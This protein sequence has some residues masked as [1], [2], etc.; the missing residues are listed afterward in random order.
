MT[1]TT[2]FFLL[3]N[4]L[5][6]STAFAVAA[7]LLVLALGKNHAR[8][9]YW[10]WWIASLKF[11]IPFSL[12]V[13]LGSH[14]SWRPAPSEP[15][16]PTVSA[17]VI[18]R[19]TQ[20]FTSNGALTVLP[21]AVNSTP[22][23]S[24]AFVPIVIAAVWICGCGL[25][26]LRWGNK[27]RRAQA[28][29]SNAKAN[30]TAPVSRGRELEALRRLEQRVGVS[31]PLALMSSSAAI[32][33]SVF[34]LLRPVL[35]W[36]AG[37]SER[38]GDEELEA[39]LLHELS[40]V[41]RHDNMT[42][43]VHMAIQAAFWFHP[44]VWWLGVRLVDERE[45]ACD[46]DVLRWGGASQL[47]AEGILKVCEYCLESPLVCAAGVTGSGLKKRV[48]NIMR[49][50]MAHPL[51][52]GRIVLL[53]VA[54][55]TALAAPIGVG[56]LSARAEEGQSEAVTLP[57]FRIQPGL[58]PVKA[59]VETGEKHPPAPQLALAGPS[60]EVSRTASPDP[61]QVRPVFDVIS[62]RPNSGA[63]AGG[64]RGGGPGARGGGPAGPMPC[65]GLI[66][67]NP[68]RF[69]ATNVTLYRLI[70][71]AYG[72]NCRLSTEQ[73]LIAGGPDWRQ[74]IAFD[75]QATLPSGSPTST[76]QQLQNGEA[77]A[78][79]MI[80]QNMLTDRFKL[81][82]HRNTKE[83]PIYNLV[84]VKMGRIKLSDDQTPPPP[85]L[86]PTGPPPPRDPSAPPLRGVFSVGVDPPAGKVNI[87][88]S[89]IPISTM[90]NFI[91]GGVGRMILDKTEPEGLY[92]IPQVELNVGPF[93][94][95]PGAVTVWPEIMNQLGLK[96]EPTRGPAEVLVIDQAEKPS[97]N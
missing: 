18:E 96:M 17:F 10:I 61:L 32:E 16:E 43:A 36:P 30:Q 66:Q 29:V 45:R 87:M 7:G 81:T 33:P 49:G 82:L 71:L 14:F 89:A 8:T 55:S 2:F 53:A 84:I 72:K 74:S 95:A 28:A 31:R 11:L 73:E 12:L 44:L 64:T 75:I 63:P 4:H 76:L 50:H 3:A 47:Y 13:T 69:A 51:S 88:A 38:L 78:L 42:A 65:G 23:R 21:V 58:A 56:V 41:R 48:E 79:Q 85:L 57:E 83:I 62:I 92:D 1:L 70:T 94:V 77:P 60:P 35:V 22:E 34:G 59:P 26:F 39:I 97:E 24:L 5:W 46:E 6:Q 91:Q 86:P 37:L 80:I 15:V 68:G 20:P 25:V 52:L 67:V 93:D 19:V 40:H 54:A 9:R 27:W 90:I